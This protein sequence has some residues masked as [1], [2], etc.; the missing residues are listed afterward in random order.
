[1]QADTDQGNQYGGHEYADSV[2]R[3]KCE[4]HDASLE[5]KRGVDT[6]QNQECKDRGI[7]RLSIIPSMNPCIVL[8]KVG[9]GFHPRAS[10]V[11]AEHHGAN[12]VECQCQRID[13]EDCTGAL[14]SLGQKEK[15]D[16]KHDRGPS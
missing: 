13:D 8:A 12:N 4:A 15:N 11:E 14:V 3:A 1:M 2:H 10:K 16:K 7:D 5:A 9:I 6:H